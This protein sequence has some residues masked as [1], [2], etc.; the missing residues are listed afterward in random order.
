MGSGF[1]DQGLGGVRG[2][3]RGTRGVRVAVRKCI[4]FGCA[5]VDDGM[6]IEDF[7]KAIQ[8]SQQVKFCHFLIFVSFWYS[9]LIYTY[10]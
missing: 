7:T 9:K 6:M 8:A 5:L 3:C 1:H 2:W 10:R 4:A